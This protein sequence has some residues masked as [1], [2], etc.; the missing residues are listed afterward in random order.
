MNPIDVYKRLP[1]TNCGTC[2][3]KACMPFAFA[4][5]KGDADLSECPKLTDKERDDM[6]CLITKTDWREDLISNLED[7][8]GKIRFEDIAA[9]LGAELRDGR[10]LMRCFGRDVSVGAGG[11]LQT[12]GILTPW[13]RMLALFYIKNGGAKKI[14]GKWVLHS[15]LRGGLMKYKAFKRECEEPLKNLFDGHLMETASYLDRQGAEHPDGF[16]TGHAWLVYVF[17]RLPVLFL[18]WPRDDEFDSQVSIRFDTTADVCFDVE[19][20]IFLLEEII[21]DIVQ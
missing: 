9:D 8:M 1:K 7:E 11:D 5:L 4:V 19:Q 6:A 12:D 14:S 15:E 20:L 17:P 2:R 21:K 3:Q 18:Y 16:S 10:L 13:M